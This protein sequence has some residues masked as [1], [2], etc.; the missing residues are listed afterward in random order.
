MLA[1]ACIA[2]AK[3]HPFPLKKK[4]RNFTFLLLIIIF[5]ARYLKTN[6]IDL[7]MEGNRKFNT[8]A[9]FEIKDGVAIIP[10]GTIEIGCSSFKN[11]TDLKSIVIPKSVTKIEVCA[12]K[13]CSN[14]TKVTIP[15][16]VT[17]AV[18]HAFSH[19][20]GFTELTIP[21]SMTSI[22]F[23]TFCDCSNLTS[24]TFPKTMKKID[25][26]A[27]QGCVS[28][29][30]ITFQS[31]VNVDSKAFDR[32]NLP[33]LKAIYVPTGKAEIFKKRLFYPTLTKVI[34]ELTPVKKT[35]T[36]AKK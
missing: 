7:A 32:D 14:L 13:D 26:Q 31:T 1:V 3:S 5:A 18:N 2:R 19:C 30:T 15:E 16:G 21:E 10:K 35:K 8:M 17:E 11:C 6:T 27:F 36:K 25:N 33:A 12:F 34:V 22:G 28:L 23:R 24:V 4:Q 29:E 20:A 9:E